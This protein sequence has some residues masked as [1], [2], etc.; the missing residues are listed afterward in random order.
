MGS[1]AK[2]QIKN[3]KYPIILLWFGTCSLTE[4]SNGLFVLK[5][6]I[7]DVVENTISEYR[8]LKN[9][10]VQLNPRAKK[11]FLDWPYYS[12]STFNTHKNKTFANNFF[13]EQQKQLKE[14]IDYIM[15]N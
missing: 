4:K 12:L 13:N 15:I 2:Y 9:K 11:V 3:N 10:L 14:A 8:E 5:N 6:Y 1:Y 7:T